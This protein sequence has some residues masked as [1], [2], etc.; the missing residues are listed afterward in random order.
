MN[1]LAGKSEDERMD[2][3]DA[4]LG[5]ALN[6]IDS[7]VYAEMFHDWCSSRGIRIVRM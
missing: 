5:D 2:M 3:F 6:S 7:M 4:E 1:E